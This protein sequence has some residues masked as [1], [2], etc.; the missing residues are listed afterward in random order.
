MLPNASIASSSSRSLS[1]V[2]IDFTLCFRIITTKPVRVNEE[3]RAQT[4][5]AV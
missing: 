2:Q 3:I 5:K 4:R 1:Y